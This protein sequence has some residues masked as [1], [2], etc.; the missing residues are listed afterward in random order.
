MLKR[1]KAVSDVM[2][3]LLK[4]YPEQFFVAS[5]IGTFSVGLAAYIVATR[6]II[7]YRP[8]Y[9]GMIFMVS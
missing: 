1:L 4:L 8:Y 3:N 6:P 7:S 2:H 9:R 5:T